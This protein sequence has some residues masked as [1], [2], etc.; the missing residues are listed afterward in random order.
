MKI[1]VFILLMVA[2]CFSCSEKEIEIEA[3]FEDANSLTIYDYLIEN[4]EDFSS[5][6]SILEKGGIDKTL[7]A[8]NPNGNGYTLFA[9][10]NNAINRFI[11]E[12]PQISS[13]DDILN[14]QEFVAAFSRFHV[15]NEEVSSNEFPFGAFSEPTL[16]GDY[17]VVSYIVEADTIYYKINNEASIIQFNIETSNGFVHLL[18]TALMPITLTSYQLLSQNPSLSIFKDAVDLTGLQ[19]AIDFNLKEDE[20]LLPVTILIEPNSIF[21]KAG[22]NSVDEL[23]SLISPGNTD[24]TNTTNPLYNY[25]LY[26]FLSGGFFIDNFVN[27]NT[28]YNTLSEIPLNINGL[29]I[30]VLINSGKEVFDP[31]ISGGDTTIINYIKILYDNSNIITQSGA[32]HFIDQIMKQH[33]PT[34]ANIYYQFYEEPL[35]NSYRQEGGTFLIENQEALSRINWSGADLAYVAGEV[36]SLA[37]NQDYLLIDGDFII[38]YTI[39]KIVQGAYSVYLRAESSNPSNAL[40]EVFIDGK[41]VGGMVDLSTGASPSSPYLNIQ[42][43]VVDFQIYDEHQIEIRPL[44]P[45]RFLWDYIQ[46][47]PY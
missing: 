17:L 31:I 16:S 38:T 47:E 45:G 11:D 3:D 1:L 42:L 21:N 44:I 43:G 4:K 18:E 5:F 23:A 2:I 14:N 29:G 32:F 46:F 20:T 37:A 15:V 27:L 34:R 12:S 22:I 13:L 39:P 25:V 30:D 33:T 35:I 40:V 8:Y 19:S 36:G 41:K 28:N 26:H 6:I 7:S 24:Y 10:D 9:P